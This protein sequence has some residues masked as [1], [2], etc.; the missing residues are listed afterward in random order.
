IRISARSPVPML[1]EPPP[2]PPTR[3]FRRLPEE[4]FL[5]ATPVPR[6]PPLASHLLPDRLLPLPPLL[7]SRASGSTSRS[8]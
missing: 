6:L 1:A 4:L 8:V 2:P 5:P 3:S 7:A